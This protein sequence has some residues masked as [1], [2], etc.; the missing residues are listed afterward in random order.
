[1]FFMFIYATCHSF[2]HIDNRN[3]KLCRS[4][5]ISFSRTRL[6]PARGASEPVVFNTCIAQ[7]QGC[8]HTEPAGQYPVI[9]RT[10]TTTV[11]IALVTV[12]FHF[13]GVVLNDKRN[14]YAPYIHLPSVDMKTKE[15]AVECF[16]G[17]ISYFWLHKPVT[18]FSGSVTTCCGIILIKE[19]IHTHLGVQ[20][21]FLS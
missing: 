16:T 21:P 5:V 15:P 1:M 8:L 2:D 19:K 14:I 17:P 20:S 12:F 3:G 10:D 13:L 18:P 7:S 4:Q 6:F 9:A 11:E